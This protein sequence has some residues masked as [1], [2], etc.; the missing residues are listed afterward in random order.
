MVGAGISGALMALALVRAGLQVI[1][2][3][4]RPPITG[5]TQYSTAL[6]QFELD[7]PLSV[8]SGKIGKHDAIR[9]WQ[10]SYQA[11]QSLAEL[12]E[13]ER[14]PCGF[15]EK[16]SLYLTGRE[17]SAVDLELEM[18]ARKAAGLPS[19]FLRR[20]DLWKQ[21]GLRRDGGILSDGSA[22]A[23]PVQLTAGVLRRVDKLGGEIHA[24]VQIDSVEEMRSGVEARMGDGSVVVADTLVYCTGYEVPPFVESADHSIDSTWAVAAR[25]ISPLPAWASQHVVWEGSD[26]YLYLRTTPA[27][28]L[29]AGGEDEPSATAHEDRKLLRT[30]ARTILAK[31]SRLL[32]DIGWE[33][34]HAWAGAFGSSST[35][36]PFIGRAPGSERI[37]SAHGFGG[38]GITHSQLAAEILTAEILGKPD[39]DA[40]IFRG[41]PRTSSPGRL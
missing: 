15:R 5:S 14:I 20:R 34:T 17:Y 18:E 32:P 28:T 31:V 23:N 12:I 4:R 39:P 21:F 1:V 19:S 22:S 11:V 35:G 7:L 10:R 27:G 16:R 40:A 3:D 29:V 36:L 26:P 33:L 24:Q 9:A 30:K 41:A 2:V 25:P 13:R 6:L 38:N 37:Y 8:L